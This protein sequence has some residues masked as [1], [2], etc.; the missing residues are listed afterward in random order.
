MKKIGVIFVGFSIVIVVIMLFNVSKPS[1]PKASPEL[2]EWN[3]KAQIFEYNG[4]EIS[5]H[6]TK[7][8]S[9]GVLLLLHGF[10]T[11]SWDWRFL[12]PELQGKYRLIAFDMLGFGLSDKPKTHE[13][14][15]H[16]QAD[17]QETLLRNLGI[18]DVNILA[19]DYGDILAQEMIARF[20]EKTENGYELNIKSLVLLN[21]GIFPE[22]HKPRFIQT[23]LNS[24]IGSLVSNFSTQQIFNNSFAPVFGEKTKPTNQEMDDLWYLISQ[25]NGHQLNHK[26]LH[27][28]DD[29][30]EYRE[31]WVGALQETEVP[32]LF[33]NGISDPVTGKET[34]ERYLELIPSPNVVELDDIGHYP[35]TE[36]PTMVIK[37]YIDFMNS[38]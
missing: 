28:L 21:G 12:W 9:K 32:M 36:S 20:N 8:P 5:Y 16:E 1:A 31:R 13:Y 27:Y 14:S 30:F 3:K 38:L 11:S 19:H 25:Q 17:I 26:L 2:L 24:P 6:D 23:L 34:V 10:P 29:R 18:K 4:Y 22:Q 33:I 37:H 7:D 15:V 35:H